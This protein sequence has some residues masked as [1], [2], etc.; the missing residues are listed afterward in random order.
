MQAEGKISE[1]L[2]LD[3]LPAARIL[4]PDKLIPSPGQYLLTHAAGSDSPL[5][6]PVFAAAVFTSGFLAA[7]PAPEAWVPG[8]RLYLRGPLGR[9]FALPGSA[10][11]LG[12]IAFDG[13]S[14]RLLG[15]LKAALK[16]EA[17]ITLVCEIPP[18]DLPLQVEIQPVRAL[19]E[20]CRW[21]DWLAIDSGRESLPE[22]K[23]RLADGDPAGVNFE[24]QVL[25]GAPMPCGGLAGCGVCAVE[26]RRGNQLVCD[27]GP[28]FDLKQLL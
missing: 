13:T 21:A 11:R 10:R 1:L 16:Q 23:K 5:A 4:C 17:S 8:T 25:V 24:A 22:L 6:V 12:L 9:G 20:V 27:Q 7:P 14:R 3:G 2:L 19:A 15:L 28:V 18:D 26:G